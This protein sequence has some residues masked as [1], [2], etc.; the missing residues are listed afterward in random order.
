MAL[1]FF[2]SISFAPMSLGASFEKGL[3]AF[4]RSDYELA[5]DILDD[6]ALDGDPRALAVTGLMWEQGLGTR[7]DPAEALRYYDADAQ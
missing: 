2:V 3:E 7:A 6:L 4:E 1:F 5:F